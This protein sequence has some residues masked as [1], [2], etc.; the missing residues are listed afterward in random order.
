M[1]RRFGRSLMLVS[2]TAATLAAV[3]LAVGPSGTPSS[4]VDVTNDLYANNEDLS[5]GAA[6]WTPP[7]A[8]TTGKSNGSQK[9]SNGQAPDHEAVTVDTGTGSGHHFGL[10]FVAWAEFS[11]SG[12]SP[13]NIAYSDDDGAHWTGP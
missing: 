13:I 1:H 11:G 2:L 7:V 6:A 8:T 12:R 4:P 5:Y 9:G 10:L 3:A